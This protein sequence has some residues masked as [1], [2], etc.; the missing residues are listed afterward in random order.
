MW[1]VSALDSQQAL[2]SRVAL[3]LC[4]LALQQSSH[5]VGVKPCRRYGHDYPQLKASLE[6][7]LLRHSALA[8]QAL[9]MSRVD[10]TTRHYELDSA[11]SSLCKQ[12]RRK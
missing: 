4:G 12:F 2:H 6:D 1:Q 5:S 3:P 10:N 7:R 11:S 8:S 9:K